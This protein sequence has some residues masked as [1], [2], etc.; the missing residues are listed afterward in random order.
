MRP[1]ADAQAVGRL[2]TWQDTLTTG[3]R[4]LRCFYSLV[5][6]WVLAA[7]QRPATSAGLYPIYPA[8]LRQARISGF[9]QFRVQ[10][11]SAG[12]PQISSFQVLASPHP[13]FDFS[14]RQA[15]AVWRPPVPRGT[16]IVE[17]TILFL[18]LPHETDSARACPRS[19]VYAVVCTVAASGVRPRIH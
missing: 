17:Q 3:V 13:G 5:A 16:R 11:D 15:V 12:R 1:A 14:V 2:Q 9:H 7:C 6:L 8:L 19:D 10:L 4:H 18:V